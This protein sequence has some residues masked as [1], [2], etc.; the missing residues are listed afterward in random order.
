MSDR[1]AY[2]KKY[3]E[4]NKEKIK[5]YF[6]KYREKNKE[7]IKAQRTKYREENREKRHAYSKK[8]REENKEK[9]IARHKKYREENREEFR[10]RT[11]RSNFKRRSLI[12][13]KEI[14]KELVEAHV[15]LVKIK[16]FLKNQ[17]EI[18]S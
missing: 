17:Q 3:R 18:T 14:P 4:K 1:K 16:R 6:K 10:D 12:P 15:T 8:Y 2:F 5:A 9:E 13:R 11:N 7:R